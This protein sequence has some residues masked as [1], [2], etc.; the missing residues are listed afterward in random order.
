M[1]VRV[2]KWLWSVRIFK[3]RSKATDAVKSGK[4]TMDGKLIKPSRMVGVGDIID[5][6]KEQFNLKLEV[7]EVLEKRVGA[8]LV[9]NYLIDHTPEEEY[10]KFDLI[11]G[12]H[13]EYRDRGIGRPTKRERREIDRFKDSE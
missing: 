5:V 2:D 4:V 12:G 1:E 13:F 6:R 11:K 9:E 8:K 10:S 3:T 7:K